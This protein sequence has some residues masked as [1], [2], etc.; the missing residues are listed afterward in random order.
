MI[1]ELLI[2]PL[3]DEAHERVAADPQLADVRPADQEARAAG[4]ER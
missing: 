1:S 4:V 2:A 3:V